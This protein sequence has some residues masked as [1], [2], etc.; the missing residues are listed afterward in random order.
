MIVYSIPTHSLTVD[1]CANQ[2]IKQRM[3]SIQLENQVSEKLI[4]NLSNKT[5][6]V[7]HADRY[8][9]F[10][11]PQLG[12]LPPAID[13]G[14]EVTI[15]YFVAKGAVVYAGPVIN[16][17]GTSRAWVLAWDTTAE[18]VIPP[19]PNNKVYVTCGSKY[20]IEKMTDDEILKKLNESTLPVGSHV[21]PITKATIH[22]EL[23]HLI[24]DGNALKA[25]FGQLSCP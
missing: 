2:E 14:K 8:I 10:S 23:T 13:A 1:C 11:T 12:P 9:K 21:D 18:V 4:A 16:Q 15:P 25:S 20:D 17:F 19:R 24:P 3:A 5:P 22:A 6:H 7:I